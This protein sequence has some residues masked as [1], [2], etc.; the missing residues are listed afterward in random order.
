[1]ELINQQ[2]L[3]DAPKKGLAWHEAFLRWVCPQSRCPDTSDIPQ[4]AL[5]P[6]TIPLKRGG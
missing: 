3:L 2:Y 6:F 4:N 5:G 1:M